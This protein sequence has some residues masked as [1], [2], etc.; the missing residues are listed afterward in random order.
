MKKVLALTLA[1]SLW[2][3]VSPASALTLSSVDGAWSNPVGGTNIN[4]PTGVP[5]GYGNGL[6][7]QVR[8]GIPVIQE[9]SGLG[10]TGVAGGATF[11]VGEVFEVGQLR[12]FNNVVKTD[13]AADSVDLAIT[14]DF[15]DPAGLSETFSFTLAIDETDNTPGPPASDISL[16]NGGLFGSH[17]SGAS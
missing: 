7:D 13:T 17:R 5:I 15:S 9:Q 14:L 12:H 11:N 2:V 4:Y 8:W 1:V 10:F 6:E 3:A 16:V